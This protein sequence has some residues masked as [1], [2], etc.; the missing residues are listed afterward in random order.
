MKKAL[1]V[2]GILI[3]AGGG[4]YALTHKQKPSQSNSNGKSSQSSSSNSSNDPSEGGRYLVIKEWGVRFKLPEGLQGDVAYFTD[5]GIYSGDINPPA[6]VDLTSKRFST[7]SLKCEYL[8]KAQ[9]VIVRISREVDGEG[10]EQTSPPPFKRIQ[11]TRYYFT[12]TACEETI[13]GEGSVQDKQLLD[14]LE[15]AVKSTWEATN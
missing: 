9:R 1:L 8:D 5:N 4:A 3:L 15:E 7:G 6:F 2:L 12:G 10:G 13:Q 14:A 11:N